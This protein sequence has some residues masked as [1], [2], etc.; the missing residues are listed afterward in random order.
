VHEV[1]AE[2]RDELA[3]AGYKL[4]AEE[5]IEAKVMEITPEFIEEVRAHG[6]KDLSMEQLIQLKH[7]DVL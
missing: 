3:A 1:T 2:Y 7:A 5:I 6:F 4:D